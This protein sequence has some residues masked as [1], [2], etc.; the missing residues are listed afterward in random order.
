MMGVTVS[1][2]VPMQAHVT[3]PRYSYVSGTVSHP[4]PPQ[5]TGPSSK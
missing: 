1:S 5:G 3:S 4:D 2:A